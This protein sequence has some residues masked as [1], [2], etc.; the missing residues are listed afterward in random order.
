MRVY[1]R[2]NK[3]NQKQKIENL[4]DVCMKRFQIVQNINDNAIENACLHTK[5][6]K[7]DGRKYI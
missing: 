3:N 7:H 2:G 6:A 4:R 5:K 1:P